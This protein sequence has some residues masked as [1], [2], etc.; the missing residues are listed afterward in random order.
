MLKQRIITA[1]ILLPIMI[2]MLFFSGSTLWAAFSS[3]ICLLGLWEYTRLAKTPYPYTY[4]TCIGVFFLFAF[5]GDWQLPNI[6]WYLVLAFW[7]ILMPLWLYHK[8]YVQEQWSRLLGIMLFIPFWFALLKLRIAP[9]VWTT[10]HKNAPNTNIT[11]LM[12]M[13]MV[14]IADSAAYFVG[15]AIGQHK[16]APVIS[17]KKS[18]EGVAGGWLAVLLFTLFV[19]HYFIGFSWW[20]LLLLA[21]VLTFVG[22]GG[23]LLESWLK[24]AAN[25][26]DSS[27]LLPGHGGVFDRVDSLIAVIAVYAAIVSI[28]H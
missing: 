7:L 18:W 16:L 25:V 10:T 20:A 17:P 9:D 27:Q 24:R 11:L 5:L 22:I 4:L 26:K 13:M 23:D 21:S 3:L 12:V 28:Y 1:L 14:W 2:Y 6:A 8:W 19:Q 15:R